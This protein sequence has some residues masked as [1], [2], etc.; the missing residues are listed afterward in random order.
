MLKV[1]KE[2][3]YCEVGDFHVDPLKGV[4][5]ALI[6]HGH[7]DHARRGS[8]AYLTAEKGVSILR[9]RLGKRL[10]VEGVPYG[11]SRLINGVKVSFHPAGHVLGA[12][13][14][15]LEHG[16]E[17]WVVSGDYKIEDDGISGAYEPVKCHTFI[18]ESTFGLPIY[19]WEPQ[20]VV[21]GQMNRWWASNQRQGIA[22][23]IFAY[24]L[25]KAQRV[26]SMLDEKQGEIFV[27]PTVMKMNEAYADAGVI[28]PPTT[29][30]KAVDTFGDLSGAVVI[31]PGSVSETAWMSAI[32]PCAK[33]SAS[34]WNLVRKGRGW[35]NVDRGFVVSD[36]VD[37]PGLMQA[38]EANEA[39]RVLVTHGSSEIV[40][41]YLNEMGREAHVLE[42]ML[43]E[44]G[45]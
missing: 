32:G 44:G 13:M 18:T 10:P 37:W 38:I 2:G 21:A 20:L 11:E 31:A 27:H 30:L 16:G 8:K 35:S 17:I 24:S 34:G 29:E 4:D 12:S 43:R 33:A 22:S 5:R 7:S 3:L 15:R 39:E 45:E 36:H 6:T 42:V 23:V 40:V 25:G 9:T 14:I 19:R 1:T 41:R 28:L 26:L